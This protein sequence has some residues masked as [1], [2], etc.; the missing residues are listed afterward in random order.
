MPDMFDTALNH[1]K[2]RICNLCRKYFPKKR[3]G[4]H[5][6]GI[7]IPMKF[8]ELT[9]QDKILAT[10]GDCES[11]VIVQ[12]LLLAFAE[13]GVQSDDHLKSAQVLATLAVAEALSDIADAL[14][15]ANKL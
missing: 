7:C 6:E 10:S 14:K 3:S 5:G 12:E 2:L 9:R 4:E 8:T 11:E 13:Q 1:G 15:D